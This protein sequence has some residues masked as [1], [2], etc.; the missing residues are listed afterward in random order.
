MRT[1]SRIVL[2]AVALALTPS[3][4]APVNQRVFVSKQE[5]SGNL[6]GLSG[7]DALCQGW[8][9]AAGLGGI[10][11]AWLS[12]GT[13][14]ARDRFAGDGPFVRT[15]GQV[16][17]DDRADLLD[18]SLD[19]AIQLDE[20]GASSGYNIVVT[21]ST[22]NGL[23]HVGYTYCDDW[24]SSASNQT[25]VG[26]A[27]STGSGWSFLGPGDCGHALRVY[28][29]ESVELIFEDGFESGN[30]SVWDSVHS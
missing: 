22:A 30:T 1:T 9:Q 2:S 25:A 21:G 19:V 7:A 26:G 23:K 27:T 20:Y 29:F 24:T 17:A 16:I 8:A 5:V 13:I 6:G 3:I 10:W 4:G 11:V 12:T 15:D 28:C 14:D 18:Y